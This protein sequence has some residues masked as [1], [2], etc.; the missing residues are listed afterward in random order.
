MI[1]QN[2]MIRFISNQTGSILQS[3]ESHV[4]EMYY[5]SEKIRLPIYFR[6]AEKKIF[7]V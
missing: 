1:N 4:D 2:L 7:K 3:A 5:F 6:F